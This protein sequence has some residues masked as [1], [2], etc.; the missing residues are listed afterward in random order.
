MHELLG[1]RPNVAALR[2]GIDGDGPTD[3]EGSEDDQESSAYL[4]N[5][6]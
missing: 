6:V 4:L 2:Y 1:S 3:L 5:I